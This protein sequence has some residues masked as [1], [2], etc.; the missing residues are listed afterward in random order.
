M[1]MKRR[2]A[3]SVRLVYVIRAY[4]PVKRAAIRDKIAEWAGNGGTLEINT[5]QGR[6][7]SVE[8]DTP[9]ALDSSLKWTQ[10][11]SLTLTAYNVPYWTSTT[12]ASVSVHM[13]DETTGLYYLNEVMTPDGGLEDVPVTLQLLN[14][15]ED[16]PLTNI[17]I[18]C[19]DTFVELTNIDVQPGTPLIFRYSQGLLEIVDMFKASSGENISLLRNRT[20]ESS[21]EL[22]MKANQQNQVK[23][24]S[25]VPLSGIMIMN[26]RWI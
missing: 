11:L 24:Q 16:T 13:Q 26:A 7:L 22:L 10:E 15:S 5:R 21:D 25:N 6:R 9:P 18:S 8:M 12:R 2:T 20:A 23:I 4:D 19:G 17:I 14:N 1:S 3:L